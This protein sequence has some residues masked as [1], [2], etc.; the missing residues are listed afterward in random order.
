MEAMEGTLARLH[1]SI[2]STEGMGM[3]MRRGGGGGAGEGGK[4]RVHLYAKLK[5]VYSWPSS[6]C[7]CCTPCINGSDTL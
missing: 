4:G 6:R 2:H 3:G 1:G 5:L 7:S